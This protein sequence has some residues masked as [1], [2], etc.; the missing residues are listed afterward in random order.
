MASRVC[1]FGVRHHGPG[2]A[3]RLVEALDELRPS[4]VLIEGPIDVSGL[5]RILVDAAMAPPVALLAYAQ[6]SPERAIFWPFATYSPEYQAACWAIR[7]GATVRFMDLPA[8][9]WLA[10]R[11]DSD[12]GKADPQEAVPTSKTA[13][14]V[15][16]LERDPIGAL[17]RA[18][19]YDDGESWWRDVI[20][21][22]PAPS[23]IFAAV[24]DAMAA[25][26]EAAAA[27]RGREAA[28]EAHMR[29]EIAK[30]SKETDGTIAVVCGAW[31]VPALQSKAAAAT[32]RAPLKGAPRQ[33]IVATWAPWTSP[34]LATASGYGAGVAAPG[35]CAHLWDTARHEVVTRW[36][37]RIAAALRDAGHLVSTAS[38]IEAER[39][40]KSLAALRNRP[41]PGF[42]ELREAAIA[43][44]CDGESLVW[45]TVA[46]KLLIGA[47][48]GRI[49]DNVPLAPLLEDLQREQKRLRLKPEALERELA[50]DLRSESGAGRSTLLHR[51]AVLGVPWGTLLDAGRSRGTFRERWTLRWEPEFAVNLVE[52]LIYGPTIEQAAAE[53]L[54]AEFDKATNLKALAD[55]VFAALTAGLPK[56]VAGGLESLEKRA[57]QT[58]DCLELLGA[59]P[60][61][62]NTIRYGQARQTDAGQLG[63]LLARILVQGALALGYAARGLDRSAAAAM[64]GVILDADSAVALAEIEGEE[65]AEW[66]NALR[67]LVEGAHVT[68]LL[69]GT[70]AR[71]LYEAGELAPEEAASLL[72]SALSPGRSVAEAAGFFE[73]FLDGG[74]ERLVHDKGLRDA[75]DRWIQ[76]LDADHFTEHLPLFRR[77]FADLDRMQRKRLLDA[78][79]G[80]ANAAL[81]GR[82]IVPDADSV[83]P[84]HLARLSAILTS[85]ST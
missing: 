85:G 55:L 34:R 65:R 45:A 39:L 7:N 4:I 61:L 42:E 78:L 3:R 8:S 46:H 47:D 64:R 75:V 49:P 36:L 15:D 33:K 24:A 35:W 38:V 66:R 32:D 63:A 68:P 60:A 62:A 29:L 21:E 56:A 58:S 37:A 12:D 25:L 30:A 40:A 73:G 26:R 13:A 23:P 79:F 81:P 48:V 57:A 54:R 27:P 9:W 80:R 69:A 1:L 70:A 5:L 17:A 52:N 67:E 28:R 14:A 43:C 71:L 50:V 2:S 19:G 59:L 74:G 82:M 16:S 51:L 22:N 20:E 10:V 76:G 41:A 44:L 18:G 11:Q 31:H 83:W 84:R 53:R 77:A 6:D 72:G